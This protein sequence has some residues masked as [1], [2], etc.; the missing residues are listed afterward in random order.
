MIT[1]RLF[2]MAALLVFTYGAEQYGRRARSVP[3][4]PGRPGAPGARHGA[5]DRMRARSPTYGFRHSFKQIAE[6]NGISEKLHDAIAGH[7][8]ANE[9]RKYGAPTVKDMQ[10]ALVRFPWYSV[11]ATASLHWPRTTHS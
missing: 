3:R 7:A 9:A 6:R 11:G 8:D 10:E 4:D 2:P 5:A 1:V